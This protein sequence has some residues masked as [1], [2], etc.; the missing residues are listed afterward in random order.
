MKQSSAMCA[1]VACEPREM[2]RRMQ[3]MAEQAVWGGEKMGQRKDGAEK[4]WGREKMGQCGTATVRCN[5]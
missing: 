4:R 1:T 2:Q 3:H 5:S